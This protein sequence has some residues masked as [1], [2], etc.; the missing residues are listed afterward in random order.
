MMSKVLCV[1]GVAVVCFL[2]FK[3]YSWFMNRMTAP[4]PHA[5]PTSHSVITL[6][7]GKKMVSAYHFDGPTFVVRPMTPDD[8]AE[9]YE[10][11]NYHHDG[12][13]YPASLTTVVETR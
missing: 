1:V 7:P 6:P 12:K 5:M 8:K 11:I 13:Y 4:E 3:V 2:L 10:V 9:T